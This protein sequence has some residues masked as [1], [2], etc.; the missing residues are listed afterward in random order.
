MLATGVTWLT[1][2]LE[3]S[4]YADYLGEG[5]QETGFLQGAVAMNLYS[6]GPF[7]LLFGLMGAFTLLTVQAAAYRR[8]PAR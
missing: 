6:M 4:R 5:G 8:R 7:L 2:A 1:G 3:P